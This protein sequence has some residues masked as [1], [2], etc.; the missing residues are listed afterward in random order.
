MQFVTVS[1]LSQLF[2]DNARL[3]QSIFPELIKKLIVASV[4]K[5]GYIRFPCGDVVYNAGFDGLVRKINS[6]CRFVPTGD[7]VWEIGTNANP[8]QKLK[9]D[10]EKR[11]PSRRKTFVF[12]TP[13]I[14]SDP[15]KVMQWCDEKKALKEWKDILLFD[16]VVLED[17]IQKHVEVAFWLLVQFGEN[18]PNNG[19]NLLE[20]EVQ[21]I[22]GLTNPKMTNEFLLCSNQENAKKLMDE[23]NAT[24][25]NKFYT[26]KSRLS[27]EH[28]LFFVIG[29]LQSTGDESI[30]SRVL[31][32]K[33]QEALD[34]IKAN[35]RNKIVILDFNCKDDE[36]KVGENTYIYLTTEGNKS[37]LIELEPLR[38]GDFERCLVGMGIS[39]MEAGKVTSD[40]NRNILCFKR[41]YAVLPTIKNPSWATSE[42]RSEIIP[43]ALVSK[44]D[45]SK[46]GDCEI[47]AKLSGKTSQEYISILDK[48]IQQDDSPIDKIKDQYFVNSKEEVLSVLGLTIESSQVKALEAILE[49]VLTSPNPKYK[50]EPRLWDFHDYRD[51]QPKYTNSIIN[52]IIAT[53]AILSKENNPSLD[54]HVKTIIDKMKVDGVKLHSILEHFPV[55]VEV[56]SKAVLDY[57][58]SAVDADCKTFRE[59]VEQQY[60]QMMYARSDML[61]IKWALHYCVQQKASAIQALR[62]NL[63]MYYANYTL[64]EGSKIDEDVEKFF[65]PATSRE[66]VAA[67]P[68]QKYDVLISTSQG[69]DVQ[70]TAKVIRKLKLNALCSFMLP[71][72][73]RWKETD[74]DQIELTVKDL[75]EI[76]DLA[77]KWLIDNIPDK[78]ALIEELIDN[79]DKNGKEANERNLGFAEE[80]VANLTIREKNEL[81]YFVLKEIYEIRYFSGGGNDIWKYR[82]NFIP[83]LEKLYELTVP[84]DLFAKYAYIF[85]YDLYHLPILNPTPYEAGNLHDDDDT[86]V[87][88]VEKCLDEIIGEYGQEIIF[89]IID[90]SENGFM[91]GRHLATKFTNHLE[92]IKYAIKSSKVGFLASFFYSVKPAE[93]IKLFESLSESEKRIVVEHLPYQEEIMDHMDG[94]ELEE[95]FWV[96]RQPLWGGGCDEFFDK[97]FNKLIK[98]DP[99]KLISWFAFHEKGAVYDKQIALLQ[100]LAGKLESLALGREFDNVR[101]IINNLDAQYYTDELAQTEIA[102]LPYFVNDLGDYPL[103]IKKFIWNNPKF[104]CRN[105]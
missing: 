38:F 57:I 79:L 77:N 18:I 101:R 55:L 84:E 11:T 85:K 98:Y 21:R 95:K 82:L 29:A 63:K 23:L 15:N 69:K 76:N 40:L 58:E 36:L 94:H 100:A 28:A 37:A 71:S 20:S 96:G 93:T 25:S 49:E 67:T 12:C 74:K 102:F 1:K 88:H 43:I 61:K 91:L 41:K 87:A 10:Y 8:F 6:D 39:Q 83:H 26:V 16:S 42:N 92:A 78:L 30:K 81:H 89:R 7:S 4:N 72:T 32:V 22:Y 75:H 66:V 46:S 33:N 52:G 68:R 45:S 73:P 104:F 19:I 59:V 53:F 3:G 51:E 44:F 70:K 17:W 31:I 14:F 13:H 35:Y 9:K 90:E 2:K 54:Y 64:P 62:V 47:V 27:I 60:G 34:F 86:K 50:K 80:Q 99:I 97:A 5:P 56:S 24:Q 105:D 103:G 65:A 48:W